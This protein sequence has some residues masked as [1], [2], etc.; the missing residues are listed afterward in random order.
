M[1]GLASVVGGVVGKVIDRVWPDP[2]TKAKAKIEM[3]QILSTEALSELQ[4]AEKIIVA[5][6]KSDGVVARNWRPITMLVFVAIIANN[7]L[8][9]P[10]A[11]FFGVDAPILDLPPDIWT[12]IQIGLGGYVVGR[13]A[14]KV[15]TAL[16][17]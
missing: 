1:I 4:A 5:E 2:E 14:E 13:S 8:L 17:K 12:L 15:A 11:N 9:V 10:W 16:K 3:M 7:Y 6:A